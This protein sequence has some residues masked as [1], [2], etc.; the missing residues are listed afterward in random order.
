M[1]VEEGCFPNIRRIDT[2]QFDSRRTIVASTNRQG[3][4]TDMGDVSH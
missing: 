3:I 2:G 1:F 4:D